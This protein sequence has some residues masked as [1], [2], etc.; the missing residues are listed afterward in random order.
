MV[1]DES[2][3]EAL[4]ASVSTPDTS[5]GEPIFLIDNYWI[6]RLKLVGDRCIKVG[7]AL[8]HTKKFEGLS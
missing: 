4:V 1:V 8:D 7:E 2:V 6:K 5:E 3:N